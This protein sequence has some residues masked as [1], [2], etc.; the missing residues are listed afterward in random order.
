MK[1]LTTAFGIKFELIA[2]WKHDN[3][4]RVEVLAHHALRYLR[5]PQVKGVE[6]YRCNYDLIVSAINAAVD[7]EAQPRPEANA[8]IYSWQA[9]VAEE[10]AAI[11]D[12]GEAAWIRGFPK[13]DNPY[14]TPRTR[15][16]W[17][18]GYMSREIH[19]VVDKFLRK[20]ADMR[21]KA[22]WE[23]MEDA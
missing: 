11:S 19:L 8:R 5:D 13:S 4:Y 1:N 6:T 18:N 9:N 20:L 12:E 16:A 17:S 15:S 3:A 7:L 21:E 23:E 2:L 10:L 14:I 22:V